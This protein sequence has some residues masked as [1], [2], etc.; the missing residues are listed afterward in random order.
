[1]NITKKV[2]YCKG[3]ERDLFELECE[4][5]GISG[6]LTALSNIFEEGD[7]S[8]SNSLMNETLYSLATHID[9]IVLDMEKIDEQQ[10]KNMNQ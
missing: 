5:E 1:M 6:T 7:C 9:R 3:M 2:G 4:L 10:I 8:I